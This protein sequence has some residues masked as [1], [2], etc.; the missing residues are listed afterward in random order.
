MVKNHI[1]DLDSTA[2]NNSDII[3]ASIEEGSYPSTMNNAARNLAKMLADFY[4]DLGGT[5]TV[6][7]TVDAITVTGDIQTL[8]TGQFL[9]FVA[10]GDNATTTPTLNWNSL[11][12]KNIK[13]IV[14]GS[15]TNLVAGD[16]RSGEYVD[17]IY[18]GTQFI[19]LN[20]FVHGLGELLSSQTASASATIDFTDI[21]SDFDLHVIRLSN[22]LPATDGVFGQLRISIDNGS[23]FIT[24]AAY[25]R[26]ESSIKSNATTATV[27][28]ANTANSVVFTGITDTQGSASTDHGSGLIYIQGLA[29]T[30][31]PLFWG[32][33][34]YSEINGNLVKTT[35]AGE[36]A[37]TT[38][39]DALRLLF[40]S[41]NIASGKAELFGVE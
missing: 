21:T 13:K 25:K 33:Y 5:N 31:T 27:E 22:W 28:S 16:I 29:A 6:A 23:T 3:G 7:G 2:L 39:I 19:L 26:M 36:Y 41:G 35:F 32:E 34:T 14:S 37:I 12:A 30:T 38:S 9:R 20:K 1:S 17:L 11:G 18:D 40:S 8:Q 24:D 15:A 4:N 10:A